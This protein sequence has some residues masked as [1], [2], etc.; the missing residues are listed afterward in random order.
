MHHTPSSFSCAPSVSGEP[1]GRD[2]AIPP[3]SLRQCRDL[4]GHLERMAHTFADLEHQARVSRAAAAAVARRSPAAAG[5][6]RVD[7]SF[8]C[9]AVRDKDAR[10]PPS[11]RTW[12]RRPQLAGLAGAAA[13]GCRAGAGGAAARRSARPAGARLS[14]PASCSRAPLAAQLGRR[15]RLSCCRLGDCSARRQPWWLPGAPCCQSVPGTVLPAAAGPAKAAAPAPAAAS[16]AAA[17]AAGG[18]RGRQLCA[19]PA[20]RGFSRRPT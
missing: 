12:L 8:T 13:A 20:E 5:C 19:G 17:A 9:A 10:H 14:R 15:R 6:R 18:A 1:S 4:H 11:H 7:S 16:E 3:H 2:R